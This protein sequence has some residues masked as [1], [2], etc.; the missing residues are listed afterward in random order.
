M[1]LIDLSDSK[2]D[3]KYFRQKLRLVGVLGKVEGVRFIE[4]VLQIFVQ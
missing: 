2:E 3:F 1:D 4:E